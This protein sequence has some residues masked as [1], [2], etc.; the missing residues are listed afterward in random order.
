[1]SNVFSS[2]GDVVSG[3]LSGAVKGIEMGPEGI[4][5]G[6]IVGGGSALAKDALGGAQ[7]NQGSSVGLPLPGL[8]SISI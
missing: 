7:H 5:G 6:A 1:M 2:I 3:A 4:I 8:G